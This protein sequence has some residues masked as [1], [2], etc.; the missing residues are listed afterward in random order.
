M[1]EVLSKPADQI[2]INDIKSLIDSQVP[3]SEQ[4][5]FKESLPTKKGNT[6]PWIE[7]KNIGDRAKNEILEEVVAFANAY[8]GVC[9]LG[10]KESSTKPPVA[11][12]ISPI[13]R[14]AE[15]A[16]SLKLVFRDRV[17]PQL[18]QIEIIPIKTDGESGII[19]CRVGQSRLAPHR[20]KKTRICPIRRSDRCE[21]MSMREIQDLTL[22]ISRGLER[23]E[24]RLSERSERFQQEFERIEEPQKAF[25]IRATAIPVGDEIRFDRIFRQGRIID[26]LSEPWRSALQN[27]DGTRIYDSID[28]EPTHWRP[29][30]R[31]ARAEYHPDF[32]DNYRFFNNNQEPR[33]YTE[34]IYREIHC[35]GLIELGHLSGTY[36]HQEREILSL[37]PSYPLVLFANLI[38]QAHLVRNQTGV[39][40]TEYA[41]EVEINVRGVS[42]IVPR[43]DDYPMPLG[44]LAPGTITF[45]RYSFGDSNEGN[46]LLNLFY[47]DFLNSFGKDT[48]NEENELEIPNWPS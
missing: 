14:C 32:T 11:A 27:K 22:N 15:L 4:I 45:P 16:E 12:E 30:L 25:G 44:K 40:V 20:D 42:A 18:P 26:D 35:D 47:R 41:I 34:Q 8:G 43:E 31:G 19:I 33:S 9:L 7:G 17:E 28:T 24:K 38:A 39:P 13:P 29:I 5:E 23:L 46:Y 37:P 48:G 36:T 1:I 3:E 6:D 10:I 2:R 21:K